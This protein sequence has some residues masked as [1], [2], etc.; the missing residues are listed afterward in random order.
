MRKMLKKVL[1]FT[2]AA[3]MISTALTGCGSGSTASTASAAAGGASSAAATGEK[4]TLQFWTI[5][6]QPTFTTFFN[7]LIKKY[8]KENP[9]I[10]VNW[11]DLPYESI[12]Q[13][14]VTATAGGTSPDVVN[15]NTQMALT[16]AGKNALVDLEKEATDAQRSIY[17]KSLYDSTKIGDSAYAFP[18]YA[19][20]NIMFYN[21]D[22]FAKAGIKDLPT[23]YQKAFD[24]AKTMKEK[25]GAYLYNPPEFFNLLFEE[26]IPVLN[27]DNTAAAF[28]TADTVK[29]IN[30]F[31][32]MT[33]KDYLPKTNWGQWDTEL[34]LFE[35][36]K[37]AIVSSSGS[38]LTRIKD[39]APDVYKKIGVAAPLTGSKDISRNALMNL[40]V[41]SKS[42][43]H[44]EA[45]KF[46]AFI[47]NDEN[48]LAFCKQTAIFPSTTKASEDSYFTS[49]T[50]T[51]EGQA[52]N[53]SAKVSK[54]SEDYSLGV[55]GQSD[56]QDAVNKV[57]E[58]AITSGQDVNTAL[59]NAETKVN[60]LL[61]K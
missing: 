32:T 37:L 5:S 51:L 34:K 18:W 12:Q 20:P 26:G 53:M 55:E 54:T 29:L 22:L 59:K 61:K 8:E 48:Q 47:T 40:V 11:V 3:A 35:T 31:K 41:P 1:G 19:S 2:M 17:I 25:T 9:N 4:T 24:E 50:S 58:A 14:L 30:S 10:T 36:Q 42:K 33:D 57:Y 15:L 28:N 23:E 56:I 45:I 38:S 16:L 7:N 43:N 60:S 6:L 44:E 27:S 46:A 39:E 13:K 49:D 52:R 21:K